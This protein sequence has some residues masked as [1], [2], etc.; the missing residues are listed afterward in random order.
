MGDL[1]ALFAGLKKHG[2]PEEAGDGAYERFLSL[3]EKVEAHASKEARAR[4]LKVP[5]REYDLFDT[6]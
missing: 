2:L 3:W 5:K 4:A 1:P 6:P